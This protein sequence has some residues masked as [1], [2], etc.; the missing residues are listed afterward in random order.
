MKH[1]E[2]VMAWLVA[3][4]DEAVTPCCPAGR[5]IEIMGILARYTVGTGNV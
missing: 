3:L 1:N 5:M 2:H 4:R